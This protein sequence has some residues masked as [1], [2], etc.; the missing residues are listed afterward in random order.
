MTKTKSKSKFPRGPL[1][2]RCSSERA[3]CR[4]RNIHLLRRLADDT[5]NPRRAKHEEELQR[6]E[7]AQARYEK[8]GTGRGAIAQPM[9]PVYSDYNTGF[10]LDIPISFG[11]VDV[12]HAQHVPGVNA[13]STSMWQAFGP[14]QVDT[15]VGHRDVWV[16]VTIV[17]NPA[18]GPPAIPSGGLVQTQPDNLTYWDG[19]YPRQPEFEPHNFQMASPS[20]SPLP[21][22]PLMYA[23]VLGRTVAPLPRS[24]S[25]QTIRHSRQ[26]PAEDAIR[27]H[28]S[29]AAASAILANDAG[30]CEMWI[31][32]RRRWNSPSFDDTNQ[33]DEI[34]N[35]KYRAGDV[36]H[37]SR[38]YKPASRRE[39]VSRR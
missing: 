4:L 5:N 38:P 39:P 22:T 27:S 7:A 10:T 37:P 25:G 32:T 11:G 35:K 3:T 1:G 23:P 6:T 13:G 9:H 26:S 12:V 29:E 17:G 30:P 8:H 21:N 19:G 20:R 28:T 24:C 14:V 34:A 15:G 16:N 18:A 31:G 36:Y 2:P 33:C